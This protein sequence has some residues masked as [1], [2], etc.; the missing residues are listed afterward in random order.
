MNTAQPAAGRTDRI[1]AR[2]AKLVAVTMFLTFDLIMFGAFVRLTDSGLGCPDW[3]GCYGQITPLGALDDIRAAASA[4]PEGPVTLPKAW[5]EMI[6]R[7]V[8]ALLGLLIIAITVAAWRYRKVLAQSPWLATVILPAVCLQGAFG[9][10]TVTHQLMPAVVTAHLLGGMSLLALLT[11]L[12]ARQKVLPEIPA[13]VRRWRPYVALGLVL[14]Y[15][16]LALGGWVSTN[17]AA[18]ACM[19]FPTCHGQWLPE[20]D[21]RSGY[22]VMRGLGELPSGELISQDALT[23]IHWTHRNFAFVVLLYFAWL[24]LK[25]RRHAGLQGPSH[26]LLA[27]LAVQLLT[28]LTSI[29]L[30]WPIVIAVL[31]NGGAAVLT[32]L[33]VTLLVRLSRVPGASAAQPRSS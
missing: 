7:Y 24:A 8:G 4:L 13:G 15:V 11:W 23:A 26:A 6:H 30:Q 12:S 29:F 14:L 1:R 20:M 28:G 25:L 17:Y 5:I 33:C 21:F 31:H 19:D 2:Y 9:A 18:L 16:Q 22:S 27:M 10:W 3:P 32:L